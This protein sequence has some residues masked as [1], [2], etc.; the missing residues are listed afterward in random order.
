MPDLLTTPTKKPPASAPPRS[1]RGLKTAAEDLRNQPFGSPAT[2]VSCLLPLLTS[3]S[4][5]GDL[6]SAAL[7]RPGFPAFAL[8]ETYLYVFLK[9]GPRDRLRAP[10]PLFRVPQPLKNAARR[11]QQE[12]RAEGLVETSPSVVRLSYPGVKWGVRPVD[13]APPAKRGGRP[14]N[15]LLT[16]FPVSC[17]FGGVFT[18]RG[19]GAR[20]RNHPGTCP[21]PFVSSFSARRLD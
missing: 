9:K 4:E 11:L 13:F 17:L 3:L 20:R 12:G 19:A 7:R 21:P 8:S 18:C 15:R 1:K 5:R 6:R 16:R 2:I 10:P 14:A